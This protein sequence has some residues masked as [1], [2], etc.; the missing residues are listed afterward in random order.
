[1]RAPTPEQGI[2]EKSSFSAAWREARHEAGRR[3]KHRAGD[4][5]NCGDR[6]RA[7]LLPLSSLSTAGFPFV[8]LGFDDKLMAWPDREAALRSPER[9]GRSLHR[10]RRFFREEPDQV[11]R[12]GRLTKPPPTRM[13][14]LP[15]RKSEGGRHREQPS[16]TRESF[17]TFTEPRPA[18]RRGFRSPTCSRS[19][20][21]QGFGT[22]RKRGTR[23]QL[24]LPEGTE[25][26][27]M[28]ACRKTVRRS[29][30]RSKRTPSR[31]FRTRTR[32]NEK[33]WPTRPWSTGST[34]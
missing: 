24:R 15:P 12:R 26:D 22:G 2:S 6:A 1:M 8:R 23:R 28:R 29:S 7:D 33:P 4:R 13:H 5:R 25:R 32:R 11:K 27:R 18:A 10:T 31:P 14:G 19:G 3:P 16:G 9:E 20:T 17:G 34:Q 21:W 30:R